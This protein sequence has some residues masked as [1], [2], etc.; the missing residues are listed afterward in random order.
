[1]RRA[2]VLALL[3]AALLPLRARAQAITAAP[4]GNMS[5]LVGMPFDV[6]FYLDMT[7]RSEKLGSFAA[8]IS[9]NPAVLHLDGGGDGTFGAVTVNADSL[10][11][12]VARIAGAN[13]A[14]V[15]GLITLGILHF[16][17]LVSQPDT[18]RLA[19]T[20]LFA[21]GTFADLMPSLTTRDGY[22]CPA[23]GVFG[24]VDKDANINS[25][26]ALIALSNAVGLDVSAF[27]VSLG[28]VD[29]NGV[30]NA[31]DALIILSS[32]V[33]LPVSAF[34]VGRLA[35]GACSSSLP[36]A[37]T[38]V[39]DTV[40]L[41][42]GQTVAFEA[43]ASDSSGALQ[44][45][46]NAIWKSA[47]SVAL[48]VFPD[49]KALAR[50][51]GT[52]RVTAIGGA[53]DSAQAVVRIVARRTRQIVDAAATNAKNQLGS[54][55]LP[56]AT[57]AQ[58]IGFA[59]DGDTVEVRVGRYP[60]SVMLDRQVVLLGDTLADGTRPLIALDSA[61]SYAGL[62]L[63]GPGARQAVN[64]GIAGY[65]AGVDLYGPS[66]ATLRGLRIS[67]T[68]YGIVVDSV[69]GALRIESSR[70][71]GTGVAAYG[72]GVTTN[73]AVGT[74]V[75]QGTEISD[76][77]W[78]GVYAPYV[79]SLAV[80]GSDIHDVG[81]DGIDASPPSFIC[82]ICDVA[83]RAP[84]RASVVQP[85]SIAF[86]LD[87]STIA[88]TAYQLAYLDGVRSAS[89]SH[90]HLVNPNADGVEVY[91]NYAGWVRVLGDSVN[92]SYD[93]LDVEY[94][95]SLSVDSTWVNSQNPY[96]YTYD[97][98]TVRMT[99]TQ[100]V[101][102]QETALEVNFGN[103]SN[104]AGGQVF[105]DNVSIIGN[106]ACDLCAELLSAYGPRV[107][108]NRITGVNLYRGLY[109]SGDSSATVTNSLFRH[110]EYPIEWYGS[111]TDSTSRLAVRGTTFSGFYDA[112]EAY[113]GGLAVDS[114]TF[115]DGSSEGVYWDGYQRARVAHNGF[116]NVAFPVELYA[117]EMAGSWIDTVADNAISDLADEGIYVD[118][119]DT[120]PFHILR[121]TLTCNQAGANN[122]YGIE[123]NY[124]S[125]V[126]G[127]NQVSGCYSGIQVYDDGS[128]PRADSVLGNT[129]TM[130]PSAYYGVYVEGS[131][132]SRIANNALTGD[133]TSSYSYG[134]IR[135][136]GYQP[137]ATATID[138]NQVTGGTT[139]GIYVTY[140]DTALV[141][142]NTVRGV[143][144][145][146]SYQGGI[147]TDGSL[148]NL[149]RVYG[150]SVRGIFGNGM[151]FYSYYDTAMVQVDSNLVDSSAADGIRM[152]GGADSITRNRITNNRIGVE[153]ASYSVDQNRSLVSGNNIVG[154]GF[155]VYQPLDATYQATNNWW[156]DVKGPRCT[157]ALACDPTSTG[158]SV[159]AGGLL[160]FAP[161]ALSE[162]GN[163]P[164]A[165]IRALPQLALRSAAVRA[166]AALA[167]VGFRDA[168]VAK[169][170]RAAAPTRPARVAR[171]VAAQAAAGLSPTISQVWQRAAQLR[172]ATA[173][174]RAQRDQARVT[175]AAALAQVQQV[176]A[177]VLE[178]RR[179]H[180]EAKVKAKQARQAATRAAAAQGMGVRQ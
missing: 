10:V 41:V 116:A 26:D 73:A 111:Y 38:I 152:D 37:M 18:V 71:V 140:L 60:E 105:L 67:E 81:E 175:R 58:G 83:S 118:G 72:Y 35:G 102:A 39:P 94:V 11:S 48:A 143:N 25:R 99:N 127:G 149:A 6:P 113:D 44:T 46:S 87:H 162:Y 166:V 86:V 78:D 85:P 129:V 177:Q 74:L 170:T 173:T 2:L 65:Y 106:P 69:T 160:V 80:L 59:R 138:S 97:V 130:P 137:G 13:P 68:T 115:Q 4:G 171:S 151:R 169:T 63:V 95:D 159:T 33:G 79:D 16:T 103:V 19:V 146:Y 176:R 114:N 154:N 124:A 107:T 64:L 91:G 126:V 77:G 123:L 21:A 172:A 148:T 150:N 57:I 30:T 55:V 121:N 153:F 40:D 117:Y 104:N 3:A 15:G 144:A 92:V 32:A 70:L 133:T 61:A 131:V 84:A 163:T 36:L 120:V 76:F 167:S 14:G 165:G 98:F 20:E 23:R 100:F 51:T 54:A 43:R 168:P 174:T 52:V 156:G 158:D 27:D 89:F 62:L 110:V 141:R 88:N 56:F 50:D 125:G 75:I 42:I 142:Y 31:R 157:D 93:W 82:E 109:V 139:A 45:V 96:G 5:S 108:A 180:H 119:D 9:W 155:G 1:M 178:Q 24:D 7:A 17:P 135:V 47:N 122:G 164:A 53:R 128:L 66:Q 112:I 136:Y 8:R 49:G 145:P 12:G 161:F 34:R 29:G 101:S 132:R 147:V 28:D 134:D 22:F 179:A 90:N